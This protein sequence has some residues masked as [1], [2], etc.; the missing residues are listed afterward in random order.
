[1]RGKSNNFQAGQMRNKLAEWKTL[2][3]PRSI[4]SI[5]SG[6]R[7]PFIRRPLSYRLDK[8]TCALYETKLSTA[9]SKEIVKLNKLVLLNI[10]FL[11]KK[12]D[13]SNRSIFDLRNLSIS[14]TCLL[15]NQHKIPGCFNIGDNLTKID[16]SQAYFPIPIAKS[17]QRYLALVYAGITYEMTCLPFGFQQH[18]VH[19][20]MLLTGLLIFSEGNQSE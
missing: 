15:I 7:I 2:G 4:L 6:Y 5:I 14:T 8:D 13:R 11:R 10:Q 19:S 9:M 16:L 12:A 3:A 18:L 1:M 20:L 17:H